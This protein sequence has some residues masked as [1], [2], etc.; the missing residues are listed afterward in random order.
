MP[1]EF[2]IGYEEFLSRHVAFSLCD[3]PPRYR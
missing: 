1:V 2:Q 3:V